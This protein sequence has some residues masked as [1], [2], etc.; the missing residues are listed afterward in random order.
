MP[1]I[2]ALG[3]TVYDIIFKNAVPVT[4][5]AG[6]SMLNTA[7]SLGRLGLDV[8]FVSDMGDDMIGNEIIMFLEK[9]G[10]HTGHVQRYEHHK[11]SLAIAFLN[12]INNAEYSF[13]RD[14][15]ENRLEGLTIDFKKDD[16]LLYGSFFALTPEIRPVL[17]SILKMASEAGCIMIYDPN[18]RKTHLHELEQLRKYI[19]ENIYYADIVRGSDEDFQFIYGAES[20][21]KAFEKVSGEGCLNLVYTANKNGVYA[22]SEAT[23]VFFEVPEIKVI[24]S[25]GAGDNFNA[26]IIRSIVMHNLKKQNLKSLDKQSW[27]KIIPLGIEFASEVCKSYDNYI[28]KDFAMKYVLE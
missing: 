7:V 22:L 28:A 8:S 11:S 3:E 4:A 27:D 21:E 2:Y 10:I 20:P 18:F 1:K 9:N 23:N 16:I 14:Y 13:Y 24:S 26:G 12:E 15:P 5:K 19:S 6:G 17:V 25:I